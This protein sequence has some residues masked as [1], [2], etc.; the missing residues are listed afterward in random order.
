MLEP[1]LN[2]QPNSQ[3]QPERPISPESFQEE[4]DRKVRELLELFAEENGLFTLFEITMDEALISPDI[5]KKLIEY[6]ESINLLIESPGTISIRE[7]TDRSQTAKSGAI[8][9]AQLVNSG[10]DIGAVVVIQP[11]RAKGGPS[12]MLNLMGDVRSVV[13]NDLR[14]SAPYKEGHAQRTDR[15]MDLQTQVNLQVMLDDTQKMEMWIILSPEGDNVLFVT[16]LGFVES[17]ISLKLNQSLRINSDNVSY[18][19]KKTDKDLRKIVRGLIELKNK[20]KRMNG[21]GDF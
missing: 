2:P 5:V 4:L 13:N 19:F 16:R 21:N 8:I 3:P 11:Q 6:A 12:I 14:D 20:A 17:G 9:D 10:A 18:A 1:Q 15:I 7:R